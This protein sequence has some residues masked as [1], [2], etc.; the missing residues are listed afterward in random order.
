[1]RDYAT[2]IESKSDKDYKIGDTISSDNYP[3]NDLGDL[4]G[5]WIN[6]RIS[7]GRRT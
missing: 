5:I 2:F 6:G 7:A 4:S 1:M 3:P